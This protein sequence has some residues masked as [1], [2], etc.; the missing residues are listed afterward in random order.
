MI[1]SVGDIMLDIY[2]DEPGSLNEDTDTVGRT[3]LAWGGSAANFAVWVRRLGMPSAIV[4][5]VGRDFVGDAAVQDFISEGVLPLVAR[6]PSHPTG[7]VAVRRRGGLGREMICDRKANA[8]FSAKDLPMMEISSASWIHVSGYTVIE[9]GPRKAV[10]ECIKAAKERRIPVSVDPGSCHLI[11]SLGVSHFM[12]AVEGADVIL[13]NLDEARLLSSCENI[14]EIS[15]SL[16]ES[17]PTVVVKLGPEGARFAT[18]SGERGLVR[19]P[20]TEAVD[21][22]G[23]GDA[24][25][26]AF[27]CKYLATC[28]I[29]AATKAGCDLGALVVAASGARAKVALDRFLKDNFQKSGGVTV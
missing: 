15:D 24:F 22:N 2:M 27:V 26:A 13:P 29:A 1:I 25:G 5:R 11:S 20:K 7:T 14:E 9:E 8:R 28:D 18:R 16:L 23:A 4:G 3:N 10:V 6:D 17:F 19:P 12:E 21:P